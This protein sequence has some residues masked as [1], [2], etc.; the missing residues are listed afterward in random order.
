MLNSVK[1]K[2]TQLQYYTHKPYERLTE[3]KSNI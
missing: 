1:N 3:I 2:I